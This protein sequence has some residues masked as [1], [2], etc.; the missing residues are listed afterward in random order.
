MDAILGVAM[1]PATT[2]TDSD[3]AEVSTMKGNVTF[4]ID[5]DWTQFNEGKGINADANIL[6]K[7]N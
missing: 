2:G 3:A 5:L 6:S 4:T 1:D 7:Q